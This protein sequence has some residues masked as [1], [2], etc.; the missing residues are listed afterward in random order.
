MKFIKNVIFIFIESFHDL[1]HIF[2]ETTL[3]EASKNV[4]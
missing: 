1:Y 4:K 3:Q 2:E